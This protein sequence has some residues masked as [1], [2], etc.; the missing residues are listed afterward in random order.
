M[1]S[2]DYIWAAVGL[3]LSLMVFSYLLGDN[4]L[5]RLAMH[6]FIGAA[7]GY[8]AVI[9]S[10]QV[11]Y[12]RLILPLLKH[13]RSTGQ[14]VLQ[15]GIPILLTV[16][17]LL[18]PWRRLAPLGRIPLAILLG[19]AAAFAISGA[20][21]GTLLPQ[22]QASI[23][24]FEPAG[25]PGGLPAAILTTVGAITSLMYYY[26]GARPAADGS[27]V[28]PGWVRVAAGI[29]GVF[30]FLTLGALFAG[31]LTS[32]ISALVERLYAFWTLVSALVR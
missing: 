8:G 32:A 22:T 9:L 14:M 6:I 20:A 15:V 1:N 17:L 4:A 12:P 28:R 16:L 31:V 19:A 10:T 18:V 21:R 24:M 25:L 11:I 29:G 3:V 27:L 23:Q 2:V 13:S 30:I 26:H 5:F 7:A